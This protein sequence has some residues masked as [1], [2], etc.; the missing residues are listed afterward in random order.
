[1]FTPYSL[2]VNNPTLKDEMKKLEKRS[3]GKSLSLG[4]VNYPVSQVADILLPQ[5]EIVPV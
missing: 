1:M 5:A 3:D 2:A 4:F